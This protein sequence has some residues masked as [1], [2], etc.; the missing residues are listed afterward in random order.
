LKINLGPPA[1]ENKTKLEFGSKFLLFKANRT[2][3]EKLGQLKLA[4]NTLSFLLYYSLPNK[5]SYIE[6]VAQSFN[7]S[8]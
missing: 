4:K 8:L 7:L 2:A 5:T 3:I 1:H 6:T